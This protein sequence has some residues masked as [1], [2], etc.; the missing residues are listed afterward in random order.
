MSSPHRA[1]PRPRV[2]GS[3]AGDRFPLTE[4]RLLNWHEIMRV[5]PHYLAGSYDQLALEEAW[6]ARSDAPGVELPEGDEWRVGVT[7]TITRALLV[8]P[9][10]LI[11]PCTPARGVD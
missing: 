11:P 8:V 3:A 5:E 6:L 10:G 9:L 2:A 7:T 1:G 4:R